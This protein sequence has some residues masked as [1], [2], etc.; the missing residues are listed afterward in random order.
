MRPLSCT[1]RV[2]PQATRRAPGV[3]WATVLGDEAHILRQP[4]GGLFVLWHLLIHKHAQ[5]GVS[6]SQRDGHTVVHGFNQ[7]KQL[8][9]WVRSS[10]EIKAQSKREEEP[11]VSPAV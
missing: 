3:N 11:L 6:A 5:S 10:Y 1:L 9:P 2:L 4:L 7:K 8:G